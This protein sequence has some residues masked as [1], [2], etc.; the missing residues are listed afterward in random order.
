M[1]NS[2]ILK[3]LVTTILSA[4][5]VLTIIPNNAHA[6]NK[7]TDTTSI[8]KVNNQKIDYVIDRSNVLNQSTVSEITQFNEQS[9]QPKLFIF[10]TNNATPTED[11]KYFEDKKC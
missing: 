4:M 9:N 2:H 7:Q 5:F 11:K 6:D 10:V 8:S 3:L 1:K